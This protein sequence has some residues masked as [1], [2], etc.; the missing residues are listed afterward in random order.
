MSL[1]DFIENEQ[2]FDK[3]AYFKNK[4][5]LHYEFALFLFNRHSGCLL[6]GIPHVFTGKKY[7]PVDKYTIRSLT[8]NYIPTLTENQNKEVYFKLDALCRDNEREQADARYIG[9]KNGV[10]DVIDKELHDFSPDFRITN[11]INAQYV[12]N[13]T[14]EVVDNFIKDLSNDDQEV[15]QLIIEMIGYGLFRDNFLQVAFFFYSPG[16]NGKSSLFKLLHRFYGQNNT[17]TLTLED[18]NSRF[19]PSSLK[20]S[21][22]NIA[23]DINA[24]FLK[25]T[26]NYKTIVTG[27]TL[28]VE[29]KGQDDFSFTPY[30]KL[31]F[32]GNGLPHT[33]DKSYGFYRR[34]VIIP[35]LREFGTNGHKKDPMIIRKLNTDYSLSS[36]LNLAI[37]GLEK[38]LDTG[39]LTIPQVAKETKEQYEYENDPVLQFI[40]EADNDL[41][42][43]LPVIEGRPTSTTYTI[44]QEWCYKNGYKPYSKAKLTRDLTRLG[45]KVKPKIRRQSRKTVRVYYL[46]DKTITFYDENGEIF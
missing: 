10:Y 13:A 23:D 17:T 35:M 28:N 12:P 33:N 39:E 25:D 1:P 38:I 45:Y 32:A 29:R 11:V 34:M 46:E 44:Y 14:S 24:N 7:E 31:L 36:L 2:T 6:D 30:V 43:Q 9:V 22:V 15:Y 27:D 21:L 5:F 37:K 16:S 20:G 8:M 40:H 26:G 3:K 41:Y 19:K 18:L 4:R 42:R